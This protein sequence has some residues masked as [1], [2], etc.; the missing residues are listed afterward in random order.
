MKTILAS[1][2]WTKKKIA[3]FYPN[4]NA[5]LR[6]A[7]PECNVGGVKIKTS[8]LLEDWGAVMRKI[9][10][11]PSARHYRVHGKF[12]AATFVKRFKGWYKVHA[13][14][15]EFAAGK[16]EWR[17]E[18]MLIES[19]KNDPAFRMGTMK[20]GK[21]RGTRGGVSN[22]ET[23]P[24][25]KATLRTKWRTGRQRRDATSFGPTLALPAMRNEPVNEAGVIYLFGTLAEQLGFSVEAVRPAFPD[26]IAKRRVGRDEWENSRIEF[27]YE[28]RNFRQHRHDPAGCDVIVC[29]THNWPECPENLEV[30][31][32]REVV[33]HADRKP[34]P[35]EA[36]ES[37]MPG[38][39]DWQAA[40]MPPFSHGNAPL[41]Q[42]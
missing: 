12:S 6:A 5:V 42:A 16:R 10:R 15:A 25:L 27:E 28:S 19:M 1:T 20:L 23:D 38:G 7:G 30:M 36:K 17:D 33:G 24:G 9:K 3:R 29:W 8:D 31:A 26:C 4:W 39:G 34:A 13:V 40:V 22:S 18:M 37:R 35:P 14:F 41:R 32:L 21:K 2:G 11:V